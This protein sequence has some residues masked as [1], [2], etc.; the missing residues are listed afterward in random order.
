MRDMASM[1]GAPDDRL[2]VKPTATL[3]DALLDLTNRGEIVIEVT[4]FG[5]SEPFGNVRYLR[6]AAVWNRR[7]QTR[8]ATGTSP[9][10]K[11]RTRASG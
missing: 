11:W 4:L 7:E 6:E 1:P 3:E 10:I 5:S 8:G 9:K 2:T